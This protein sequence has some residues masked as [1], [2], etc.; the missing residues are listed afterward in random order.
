VPGA[1]AAAV[2]RAYRESSGR[3]V[4]PS[5]AL[6]LVDQLGL[7]GYHLFHSTRAD[8][9]RRLGRRS[10]AAAAY[11]AAIARTANRAEQSFLQHRRDSL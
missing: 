2:E 1:D 10:E 4:S 7:D 11:D 8:L 5:L 9:L 3:A 6:E